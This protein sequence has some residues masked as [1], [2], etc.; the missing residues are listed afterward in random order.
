MGAKVDGFSKPVKSPAKGV[1]TKI[2]FTHWAGF[3]DYS[4]H[5]R[6]SKTLLTRFNHLSEIDDEILNKIGKPLEEGWDGNSVCVPVEAGMLL[7]K[8]L[9]SMRRVQPLIWA[10][11]TGTH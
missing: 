1:I 8:Q 9:Q 4:V 3:S 6:H 11:T 10:Y 7:E 2:I 5:I